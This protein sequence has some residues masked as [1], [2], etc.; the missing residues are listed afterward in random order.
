MVA[1]DASPAAQVSVVSMKA[2]DVDPVA[3]WVE[4][5]SAEL[6]QPFEPTHDYAIELAGRCAAYWPQVC[7][8]AFDVLRTRRY[9]MRASRLVS[10][11]QGLVVGWGT[12][13]RHHLERAAPLIP[14]G[15]TQRDEVNP[16]VSELLGIRSSIVTRELRHLEVPAVGESQ[17][18]KPVK[19]SAIWL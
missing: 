18:V 9:L 5:D 1:L 13:P 12:I 3:R 17:T 6:G 4:S 2:V 10:V 16:A 15:V 8:S 11:D 14:D 7:S 19:R